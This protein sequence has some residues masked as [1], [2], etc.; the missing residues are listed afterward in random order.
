MI[1]FSLPRSY[2]ITS[3][4][5]LLSYNI[6]L[7]FLFTFDKLT[8]IVCQYTLHLLHNLTKYQIQKTMASEFS[9]YLISN[10][11]MLLVGFI[12]FRNHLKEA[13]GQNK[14]ANAMVSFAPNNRLLVSRDA[15]VMLWISQL[16]R[17]YWCCSPPEL[18]SHDP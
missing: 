11:C 15:E 18:W 13:T 4:L 8:V 6:Y 1:L 16:C 3:T 14:P 17:I 10:W 9:L 5:C 12:I 7:L 2:P